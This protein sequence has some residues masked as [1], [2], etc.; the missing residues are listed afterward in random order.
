MFCGLAHILEVAVHFFIAESSVAEPTKPTSLMWRMSSGL[1]SA[2]TGAVTGTV[3]LGVGGVKWV[4]GKGYNAGS[5]VISTTKTVAA[6]V[7]MPAWK[8]KDKKE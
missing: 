6:K 8:R 7:P 4:A 3:G 5:A 1:Y 2:T